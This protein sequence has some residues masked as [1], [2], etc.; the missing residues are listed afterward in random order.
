MEKKYEV[1]EKTVALYAIN[2]KTRVYEE[3][4]VFLVN[5]P[6]NEIMEESCIYFGSSLEGR[7]KGT[8]KLIGSSYKAPIIVE[9]SSNLIFFPTKSPRLK[10][11]SWLRYNKIKS[12]Y[13]HNGLLY[14]EFKNG[15]KIGLDSSYEVINNQILRSARLETI[16]RERKI[17][18]KIS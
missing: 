17:G 16:L 14:I 10:N 5:Q 4:K 9:E 8:G 11:C 2:D 13:Y 6:T 1:N 18:E 3:D 7:Q 15:F 12:M